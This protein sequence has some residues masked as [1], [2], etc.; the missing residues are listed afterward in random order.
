MLDSSSI[1]FRNLENQIRSTIVWICNTGYE[2]HKKSYLF[3]SSAI[4][5]FTPLGPS[6]SSSSLMALLIIENFF[7]DFPCKDPGNLSS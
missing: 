1:R 6:S 5:A 2:S 3:K 7:C 4:K